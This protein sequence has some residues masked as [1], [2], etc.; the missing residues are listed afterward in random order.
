M[1]INRTETGQTESLCN[2]LC[3]YLVFLSDKAIMTVLIYN[4][5]I[6]DE[7]NTY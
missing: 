5:T 2:V 3:N 6:C 1:K 7:S 4:D